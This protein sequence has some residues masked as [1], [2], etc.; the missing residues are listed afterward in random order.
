[1]TLQQKLGEDAYNPS[2]T[3]GYTITKTGIITL[4]L[5]AIISV[6]TIFSFLIIGTYLLYRYCTKPKSPRNRRQRNKGFGNTEYIVPYTLKT[7][8]DQEFLRG[9]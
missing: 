7:E 1:V 2:T 6:I 3:L 8:D 9:L 5:L 4:A